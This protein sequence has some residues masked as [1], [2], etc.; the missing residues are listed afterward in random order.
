MP[1]VDVQVFEC[2]DVQVRVCGLDH[3]MVM[4]NKIHEHMRTAIQRDLKPVIDRFQR[5]MT[6]RVVLQV[7]KGERTLVAPP[8]VPQDQFFETAFTATVM[9]LSMFM[10]DI[11]PNSPKKTVIDTLK[12]TVWDPDSLLYVPTQDWMKEFVCKH[13]ASGIHAL[14]LPLMSISAVS[15]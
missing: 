9:F 14:C 5:N 6:N 4:Y 8:C 3:F 1:F 7:L 11:S 15:K 13:G 12:K 10:M 2:S